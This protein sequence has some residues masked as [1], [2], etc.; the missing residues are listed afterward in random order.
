MAYINIILS[1]MKVSFGMSSSSRAYFSRCKVRL[2]FMR[3]GNQSLKL[4]TTNNSF[5]LGFSITLEP[6]PVLR[7]L[8][9]LPNAVDV[10]PVAGNVIFSSYLI[11]S[12]ASG[13]TGFLAPACS[14]AKA[15]IFC[16]SIM[17]NLTTRLSNCNGM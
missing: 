4:A 15:L 9:L 6:A 2:V 1:S 17:L 5:S 3:T 13:F 10:S 7:S 12:I 11:G 14:A 8:S 16:S